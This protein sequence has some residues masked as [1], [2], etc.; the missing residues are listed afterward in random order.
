MTTFKE[1]RTSANPWCTFKSYLSAM[2]KELVQI[3][4]PI[5]EDYKNVQGMGKFEK[6]DLTVKVA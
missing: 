1:K 5:K 2:F 3:L 4:R 6:Q